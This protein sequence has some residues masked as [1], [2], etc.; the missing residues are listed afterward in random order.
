MSHPCP[1]CD[2]ETIYYRDFMDGNLT[3]ESADCPLGHYTYQFGHDIHEI[4]IGQHIWNWNYRESAERRAE[5]VKEIGDTVREFK[6]LQV[7]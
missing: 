4:R 2:K 7:V 6:K 3:E 5:R 1:I